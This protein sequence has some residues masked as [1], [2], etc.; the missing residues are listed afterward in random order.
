MSNYHESIKSHELYIIPFLW[1]ACHRNRRNSP[2]ISS[3]NNIRI[4]KIIPEMINLKNK[5]QLRNYNNA[6]TIN[7]F[8]SIMFLTSDLF[9]VILVNHTKNTPIIVCIFI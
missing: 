2:T 7:I 6:K 8:C 4:Q 1:S 9:E 5:E 3:K